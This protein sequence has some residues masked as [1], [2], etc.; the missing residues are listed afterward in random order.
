M[1]NIYALLFLLL[2]LSGCAFGTVRKTD[3][4]CSA[5]YLS[6]FKD[7]DNISMSACGAKG[8]AA[9]SRIADVITEMLIRGI[10][11]SSGL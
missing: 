8:D 9:S 1:K 4:E 10:E 3:V 7:V 2:F 11:G 5:S 6:A